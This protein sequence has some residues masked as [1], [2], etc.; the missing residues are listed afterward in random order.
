MI[1]KRSPDP[2]PFA[3]ERKTLRSHEAQEPIADQ[4][5]QA[6]RETASASGK[7]VFGGRQR[8]DRCFIQ[9]QNFRTVL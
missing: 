7:N 2:G 9:R 4:E 6:F 8:R 5:A 3:A 1:D